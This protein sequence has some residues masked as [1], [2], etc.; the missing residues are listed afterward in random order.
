MKK[1]A[2]KVDCYCNKIR[3]IDLETRRQVAR[4]PLE[5]AGKTGKNQNR[6]SEVW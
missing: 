2:L 1:N 6:K 5:E 3:S 4:K